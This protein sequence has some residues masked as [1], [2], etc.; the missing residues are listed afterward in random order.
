MRGL[1]PKNAAFIKD[2][3]YVV[4]AERY[5]MPHPEPVFCRLCGKQCREIYVSTLDNEPVG[6][7]RCLDVFDAEEW[8]GR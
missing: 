1:T 6:C 3:P 8:E 5:G 2:A 4:D 7:D